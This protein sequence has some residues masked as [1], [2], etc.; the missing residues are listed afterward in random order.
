MTMPGETEAMLRSDLF[1]PGLDPGVMELEYL[2]RPF[3]HE[4]VVVFFWPRF[5]A[6]ESVTELPVRG[7]SGINQELQR[8][9]H[10]RVTDGGIFV[11]HSRQQ[12]VYGDMVFDSRKRRDNGH[13]LSGD[14]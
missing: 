10:R 1:L 9:V 7:E 11:F 3:V 12:V 8:A 5:E 6:G 2:A 14:P 13:S 4:V